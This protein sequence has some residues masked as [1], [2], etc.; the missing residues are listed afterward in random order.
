M[1]YKANGNNRA[2]DIRPSYTPGPENT[3]PL[4]ALR[5]M[6]RHGIGILHLQGIVIRVGFHLL[7]PFPLHGDVG[8]IFENGIEKTVVIRLG[9][10]RRITVQC[11]QQ[12]ICFQFEVVVIGKFQCDIRKTETI[13]FAGAAH[14]AHHRCLAVGY[15]VHLL[16]F[17]VQ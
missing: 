1:P 9:Q 7:H 4:P 11:I 2:S 12:K 10:C 5:L 17:S 16:L 14:A 8:I 6:A 15:K 3:L 13:Q